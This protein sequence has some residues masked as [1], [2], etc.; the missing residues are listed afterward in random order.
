MLFFLE[1]DDGYLAMYGCVQDASNP[2]DS[3]SMIPGDFTVDQLGLRSL[4]EEDG[5]CD[6]S[7]SFTPPSINGEEVIPP[8]DQLGDNIGAEWCFCTG[9][10]CNGENE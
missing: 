8:F 10:T 2:I 4:P 6:S 3:T 1:G 7:D 5:E 9:A